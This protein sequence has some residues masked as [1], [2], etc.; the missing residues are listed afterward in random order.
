[1]IG[2]AFALEH[3]AAGIVPLLRGAE[4]FRLGELPCV[5]GEIGDRKVAV[6]ILGMGAA[7]AARRT[8]LAAE[9]FDLELLVLAGYAG[10]LVPE[11]KRNALRVAENYLSP[12]A[13]PWAE[14][15][16]AATAT[17]YSAPA[18]AGTSE[19]RGALAGAGW[20]MV[21]M[22]TGAV[23]SA[24]AG[25]IPLLPLRVISDEAGD[26][27]PTEALAAS[28]D[29]EKQHP[30]AW[31]LLARLALHPGEIAPF[32]RFVGHLGPAR[33]VLTEAV[34]ALVA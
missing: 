33:K 1:M 2:L 8:A 17:L 5:V 23:A 11:L 18:V 6:L 4:R 29:L 20:Q 19:A 7:T 26:V 16:G 32:F 13:R 15:L 21:D 10:A 25:R 31:G 34:R 27:L 3:E 30:D 22:E 9:H 12:A 14:K 28:F 24:L